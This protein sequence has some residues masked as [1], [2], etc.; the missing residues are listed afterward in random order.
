M[1]KTS[2]GHELPHNGSGY[3]TVT[4]ALLIATETIACIRNRLYVI[5]N[6]VIQG[7]YFHILR[8]KVGHEYVD[9]SDKGVGSRMPIIGLVHW[10]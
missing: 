2:F 8:R 9:F 10:Q 3:F 5:K 1:K 6:N 7:S 4:M